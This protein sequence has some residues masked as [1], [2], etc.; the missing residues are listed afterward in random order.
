VFFGRSRQDRKHLEAA[1]DPPAIMLV[2]LIVLAVLA[3]AG[4]YLGL[5]HVLGLG[6]T[7]EE[8]L[9]PVFAGT[10]LVAE[11]ESAILEWVMIGAAVVAVAVGAGLA[12]W[13]Y[14]ARAGLA[15][16]WTEGAEWLHNLLFNAYYVDRVYRELIV[17]P[18]RAVGRALS[19]TAEVMGVDRATDGLAELVGA[20]GAGVRRL[21]TGL[22]RNY[23]LGMLA[24]VVALL[25]YFLVHRLFGW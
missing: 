10:T 15:A 25:A 8:F 6:S 23:A 24:G 5:P 16:R 13:L 14:L 18:L 2:P 22:V 9:H 21:Q 7:I 17:E 1:H 4:G 19:G 20:I 11:A 3:F 12:Y